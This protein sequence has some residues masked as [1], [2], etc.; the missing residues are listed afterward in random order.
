MKE[1]LISLGIA[2]LVVV[3]CIYLNKKDK[4]YID[5]NTDLNFNLEDITYTKG[6]TFSGGGMRAF[7]SHHSDLFALLYKKRIKLKNNRIKFNDL[8][9]TINSISGLS[10]G[11]WYISMVFYDNIFNNAINNIGQNLNSNIVSEH[12]WNNYLKL[13]R[14]KRIGLGIPNSILD[15]PEIPS[16]MTFILKIFNY[17]SPQN[18]DLVGSWLDFIKNIQLLG[19]FKTTKMK[20]KLQFFDNIDFTFVSGITTDGFFSNNTNNPSLSYSLKPNYCSQP[21]FPC[22]PG[23]LIRNENSSI[24]ESNGNM[25]NSLIFRSDDRSR[26]IPSDNFTNTSFDTCEWKRL[27]TQRALLPADKPTNDFVYRCQNV[28]CADCCRSNSY[29]Q[30]CPNT[31]PLFFS[32]IPQITPINYKNMSG[33]IQYS[34]YNYLTEKEPTGT[35]NGNI[36]NSNINSMS[37]RIYYNTNITEQD[38]N[39]YDTSEELLNNCSA[40]SCAFFG[41][42]TPCFLKNCIYGGGFSDQ[43]QLMSVLLSTLGMNHTPVLSFKNNNNTRISNNICNIVNCPNVFNSQNNISWSR[44]LEQIASK[45]PLKT[46]DGGLVDGGSGIVGLIRQH[47][48]LYGN[49]GTM[50]IC[51]LTNTIFDSSLTIPL[52]TQDDPRLS[53]VSSFIRSLFKNQYT[54]PSRPYI[55]DLNYK[56]LYKDIPDQVSNII[57]S[58]ANYNLIQEGLLIGG[59]TISIV[60]DSLL[61]ILTPIVGASIAMGLSAPLTSMILEL[62]N[63][64]TDYHVIIDKNNKKYDSYSQLSLR[65]AIFDSKFQDITTQTNF[66]I[67]DNGKI[68]VNI[69]KYTNLDLV[70]N[71]FLGIKRGTKINNLYIIQTFYD[72]KYAQMPNTTNIADYLV[73]KDQTRLSFEAVVECLNNNPIIANQVLDYFET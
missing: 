34:A 17:F 20:D 38:V 7:T 65:P 27:Y 18:L 69:L 61:S 5:Y 63:L 2:I 68:Y 57:N 64:D 29:I 21:E 51:C 8:F 71:L 25:F 1:V 62:I 9:K 46:A 55:N 41:S 23:P 36:T 48:S 11:S 37:K 45:C 32:S 42:H 53:N 24:K 54:D 43:E 50:D 35:Y 31:L 16:Y 26:R 67:K 3:V 30:Q 49:I 60:L 58:I 52:D 19:R 12:Y 14:Q 39:S 4:F 72:Y 44:I 59:T 22:N 10:G 73:Y 70:D 56:S 15:N 6:V 40:S 33:Q 47:Q 13:I 66:T 28:G